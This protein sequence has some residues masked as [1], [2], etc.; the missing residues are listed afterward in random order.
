[1]GEALCANCRG[2]FR[3]IEDDKS[4]GKL[5]PRNLA[6]T[7]RSG[8]YLC[9]SLIQSLIYYD[10]NDLL[11]P[12]FEWRFSVSHEQDENAQLIFWLFYPDR[13]HSCQ[14]LF[15]VPPRQ[16]EIDAAISNWNPADCYQAPA[17]TSHSSLAKL[18]Q[19]WL[20]LCIDEHSG[21]VPN[22]D[23][24][25]RPPRLL[26]IES[27]D[28]RLV[29]GSECPKG[30]EWATLSHC[31]GPHP[32]FLTLTSTNMSQ[33]E[34][35]I[36]LDS[37]PRT[38][39]DAVNFCDSIGVNYLW[40]DSL[41]IIQRGDGSKEDWFHHMIEM[42]RVYQNATLNLAA[43]RASSAEDGMFSNRDAAA[44]RRPVIELQNGPMKGCWQIA[45]DTEL[46]DL[47]SRSP[48]S[49]RAWVVQERIFSPRIVSFSEDQ[50]YWCCDHGPCLK[51][52]RFPEGYPTS[53]PPPTSCKSLLYEYNH[54]TIFNMSELHR[55]S[56]SLQFLHE[57]CGY[58]GRILTYPDSDKFAAFSGIA[59]EYSRFY[60]EDYIAGF[61]R[62]HL[63]LGLA[64]KVKTPIPQRIN[65]TVSVSSY[66]APSW[67][68]AAIDHA[69]DVS[70]A[71]YHTGDD[72]R[73]VELLEVTDTCV[74][75]VDPQNKFGPIVH[76]SLKLSASLLECSW[77]NSTEDP[78]ELILKLQIEDKA[79]VRFDS[80][81]DSQS[82]Q[83]NVR[84]MPLAVTRDFD[85]SDSD[86]DS[87]SSFSIDVLILR[88]VQGSTSPVYI[89]IGAGVIYEIDESSVI[90]LFKS[91]PREEIELV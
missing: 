43:D 19:S 4:N 42:R 58:S 25:Y 3:Q 57:A 72:D 35:E 70:N 78:D 81:E 13:F 65:R 86:S 89:R 83:G 87:L 50:V 32:T 37:L 39:R 40:I 18:V 56:V 88:W 63:P 74:E 90:D 85:S 79:T 15:N 16:L 2:V 7:A 45:S 53:V 12:E 91:L 64:W 67:S 21:P 31:W 10:I 75:L 38:F 34:L 52:E 6:D 11:D 55:D 73:V 22:Q 82:N 20:R 27:G 61:F 62:S 49:S 51:S 1:M 5:R 47:F 24:N 71:N 60:K 59:E 66:R 77:D 46:L 17:N 69:L 41:C 84:L 9:I 29:Q 33:F 8:C 30:S 36:P 26:H 80:I 23:N 76:A 28:L 54:E 44:I 14:F 48:L 68:W